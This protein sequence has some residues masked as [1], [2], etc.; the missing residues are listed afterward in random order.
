MW[1][2]ALV[3]SVGP[4]RRKKRDFTNFRYLIQFGPKTIEILKFF[5]DFKQ[6]KARVERLKQLK[7]IKLINLNVKKCSNSPIIAILNE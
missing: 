2:I 1:G 3:C 4:V 5:N 6:F 7:L